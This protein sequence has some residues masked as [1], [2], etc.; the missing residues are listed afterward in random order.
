VHV[1]EDALPRSG[2]DCV[3]CGYPQ[4]SPVAV[5]PGP[6]RITGRPRVQR[7]ELTLSLCSECEDKQSRG[8]F[9]WLFVAALSMSCSAFHVVSGISASTPFLLLPGGLLMPLAMAVVYLR[10][11]A[12][13]YVTH[14]RHRDEL[15]FRFQLRERA[16]PFARANGWRRA[17]G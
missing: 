12:P 11:N 15:S 1:P 3:G 2:G 13:V 6:Y 5:A 16:L 10:F 14:R 7:P 9:P 17:R 8:R 4:A